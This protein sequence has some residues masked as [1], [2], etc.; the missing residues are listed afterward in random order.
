[1][2]LRSIDVNVYVIVFFLTLPTQQK[3]VF[4]EIYLK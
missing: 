2:F 4:L 1:M 3:K